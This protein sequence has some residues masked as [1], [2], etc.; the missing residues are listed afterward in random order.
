MAKYLMQTALGAALAASV[1]V[2]PAFS[3]SVVEELLGKMSDSGATVTFDK[4]EEGS[5]T[6]WSNI[7]A[8]GP[9]DDDGALTID[10][11]KEVQSGD[12][13][14]ITL[15]PEAVMSFMDGSN[16]GALTFGNDGLAYLV[17]RSGDGLSMAYSATSVSV[18]MEAAPDLSDFT[19]TFNNVAGNDTFDGAD[20]SS[21]GGQM[22]ASSLGMTIGVD[23]G[24]FAMTMDAAYDDISL[25]YQYEGFT[26]AMQN[27]PEELLNALVRFE[28]LTG[29]GSG[30]GDIGE[31]GQK[32]SFTFS[33]GPTGANFD[34]AD[35]AFTYSGG[36]EEIAYG[37]NP[38]QMG[39]PPFDVSMQNVGFEFGMPIAKTDEPGDVRYLI[40]MLGLEVSE[41]LWRMVDP[42]Q[43]IPRDPADLVIDLAAT[44]K[45]LISPADME[46]NPPQGMPFEFE[47]V[48]VNEIRVSLGGAE[49]SANGG[50]KMMN[51]GPFP[52]P[53]GK[54]DIAINGV[55]GLI[56]KL[57]NLGLLTPDM[58]LPIRALMGVYTTPVGDDQMTSS[59]EMTAD[60]QILANG[61]P[62]PN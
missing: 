53:I 4:S 23:D 17:N 44:A 27:N 36:A 31:D 47:D 28:M 52:L 15:A 26:A 14:T 20:W 21:G 62:L 37:V 61:L 40:E 24:D 9:K 51:G 19:M 1:A 59:V 42:S 16:E 43:T 5:T 34:M 54:L 56:D 6:T 30:S 2:T 3:Q 12:A 25:S 58:I 8:K 35:G 46:D 50:A 22:Q 57:T 55:N 13:Y 33:G 39:F 32:V 48:T 7:V 18:S 29:G 45:W 41:G 60:G 49:I 10:W 38:S 11:V